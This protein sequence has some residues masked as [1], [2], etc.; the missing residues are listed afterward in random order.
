MKNFS[1]EGR[2]ARGGTPIILYKTLGKSIRIYNR[3]IR[4]WNR[5]S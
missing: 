3:F 5:Y 4:I 2:A 1:G